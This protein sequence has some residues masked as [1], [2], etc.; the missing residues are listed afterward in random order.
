MIQGLYSAATAL[1]AA[2][3]NQDVLA[4]NI[5]NATVPGYRQRSVSFE[6]FDRAL[7]QTS[8]SQTGNK[9][10]GTRI[11]S[12]YSNFS[13]GD[14]QQTG[15]QLDLAVR[16]DGFFVLD[17]PNGPLYTRNGVFSI[18]SK[19]ELQSK[20]GLPVTGSGGRIT[21]PPNTAQVT[22]SPDGT[23][24]AGKTSIGKINL[25]QFEDPGKLRAVG[26]TLFEAPDGV[27]PRTAA[28]TVLQGYRESSNV[29][30]VNE[31]ALMVAGMRHYEAARNALKGLSDAIQRTTQPQA[32]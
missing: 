11:G 23:V 1:D 20:D 5:A 3:Q 32:S 22:V 17:G 31:M 8:G 2:S 14:Y 27:Q 9:L 21:I 19:G 28:G 12:V 18:N 15:S 13:P 6:T 4:Y 26:N 7:N 29:Q 24:L 30:A 10:L 25:A 16:G